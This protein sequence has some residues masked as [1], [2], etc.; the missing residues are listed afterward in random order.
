M[1]K[2][3][4]KGLTTKQAMQ[5]FKEAYAC[6]QKLIDR[7]HEDF[8]WALG[9]Q[10]EEKDKQAL[11]KLGIKPI[12]DNRIQPNLFLLTGLERQNR[13]DFKAFPDGEEDGLKAEIASILFKDAAKK[14]NYL[15]KSSEQFKDGITCGE[16][17]LEFYLD[18]T[19]DLLNGKLCWK[20]CDGNMLFADPN[21]REYD[22][23]DAK[24]VYKLT[25]EVELA[26]MINLYPK[27]KKKLEASK[28]GK[29]D[30]DVLMSSGQPKA[31]EKGYKDSE[32]GLGEGEQRKTGFDLLERYY[33]KWVEKVYIGDLQTGEVKEMPG[34]DEANQF[35]AEYKQGIEAD[36]QAYQQALQVH[37]A[38]FLQQAAMMNPEIMNVPPQEV[39]PLMEES[40]IQSPPP[41]PEQDLERF[42]VILKQVPEIWCMAMT[43][44]IEDPLADERAWFFPKWK[45]YPF[46][47]Y[48]A[49]FSTAPLQGDERHL[50]VQGV[51]HGVKGAQEK[52]NKAEMLMIRHLNTATNSGW[53]SEEDSW[54]DAQ[55]VK[56]FGSSPGV[57][58][59]YKR[60]RQKPERITPVPLSRGHEL[61]SETSAEAIK[62]QLGINADLLAATEGGTDSGRA[63]ALRQKQ[64]LLMVQELFDNHSRTKKRAGQMMLSQMGEMYDTE[65]T[66]KVLGEA[67]MVKNFPPP[68]L[69]N[70]E[71]AEMEPML[72]PDGQPMKY[73]KAMAETFIAEVLSGKLE[74]YDV[75]V[76][77]SVASDTQRLAAALEIKELATAVPGLVPPQ[78]LVKFSE[79][80]EEAKAEILRAYEQAQVAAQNE[81]QQSEE[82]EAEPQDE[83][84]TF[85]EMAAR[86][87]VS[88]GLVSPAEASRRLGTKYGEA[89]EKPTKKNSNPKGKKK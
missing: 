73:D 62:L 65:T 41:P 55:K 22:L 13:T 5:D 30:F 48:Y 40:G 11:K 59:Q 46:A 28:G 1:A 4:E 52:H 47:A 32:T 21:C 26:D 7:Q 89:K 77:E 19:D 24:Y 58:L 17:H 75:S 86:M 51:V 71:T 45:K 81:Q 36:R 49:R 68:M 6:K 70:P 83:G 38:P 42:R 78:V 35:I 88:K 15:A 34:K 23:D 20:K 25:P 66:M 37:V 54:V 61:I 76:G 44:S 3:A 31:Q 63:I 57:D 82:P 67:F 14:S 56:Q 60:N 80:P 18:Y 50:L 39:L 69:L 2:K 74:E 64:G 27:M 9:E 84:K 87:A 16:S 85:D 8:L 53:L 29:L 33:K 10:W 72:G 79:I 12:V 43:P